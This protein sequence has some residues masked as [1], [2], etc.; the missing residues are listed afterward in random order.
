MTTIYNGSKGPTEIAKMNGKHAATAAAKLRREAPD[1]IAEIEALE[2][3]AA[4]MASEHAETEE[5]PRAVIG[6]NMPPEPVESVDP[7]VLT[8]RTAIEAHISDMLTEASNWADGVPLESQAQ[9]DQVA[10][11][12]RM[13]EQARKLVED[14]AADEKRP[15]N[16]ALA[17]IAAWQNGFTAKGLKRTPDGKITLALSALGR[18]ST[19]WLIK[20]DNERKAKEAEAAKIAA[21]ASAA[22]LAAR[23]EAET[24]TN[25]AVVEDAQDLMADAMAKIKQAQSIGKARVHVGGGDGLRAQSLR[26]YWSAIPT[27]EDGA[28]MAALRHYLPNEQFAAELR[29]LIQRYA[30]RDAQTEAGRACPVPGFRFHEERRAV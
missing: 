6:G 9:A 16:D 13:I 27:E 14:R 19:G 8:G 24:T 21:E 3:H 10:K 15:H 22:A 30:T 17:E 4:R 20:L 12:V 1:R 18:L 25:L 28:W 5:N 23:Q 11:L 29:D 2:A 7:A 26:S